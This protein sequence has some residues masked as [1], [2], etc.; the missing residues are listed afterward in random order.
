M[1]S[2]LL[3]DGCVV[4]CWTGKDGALAGEGKEP[5]PIDKTN[6]R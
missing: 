6:F 3:F 5:L 1:I 4:I 2:L